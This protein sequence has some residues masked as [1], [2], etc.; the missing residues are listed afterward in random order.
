MSD[1]SIFLDMG[2][3]GSFIWPCY[4]VSAFVLGGTAVISLRRLNRA[5]A[6]LTALEQSD[7]E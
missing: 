3:Y 2:G 6:E 1:L 5:R 4:L 7:Q